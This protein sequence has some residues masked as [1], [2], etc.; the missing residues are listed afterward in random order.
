M[1]IVA[2]AA[3]ALAAEAIAA[4][5]PGGRV[6]LFAGFGDDGVAQVDLN[7]IH[8]Q[9]IALVGSEWVGT[10]PHQRLEHYETAR[11]LLASE[12][13]P[14][15]QLVTDRTGFEGL[16]AALYAVREQRSLKTVLLP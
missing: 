6:V 8:Y 4:C 2:V 1:V 3:A 11:D 5:A 14:L 10:P 15:E 12:E 16:E 7:R 9:E 13:L